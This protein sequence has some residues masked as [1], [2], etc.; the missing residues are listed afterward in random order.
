MN[1]AFKEVVEIF[2]AFYELGGS[3]QVKRAKA[4]EIVALT[5]RGDRLT[6]DASPLEKGR[7][8]ASLLQPFLDDHAARTGI[9]HGDLAKLVTLS[10]WLFRNDG[11][12]SGSQHLSS[13][14]LVL[15]AYFPD[16]FIDRLA[17][18]LRGD[19]ERWARL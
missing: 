18:D 17:I 10:H 5:L 15:T 1:I 12:C 11:S 6:L 14:I 4:Q 3:D 13:S 7:I 16:C 9:E 2:R 19:L 8:L